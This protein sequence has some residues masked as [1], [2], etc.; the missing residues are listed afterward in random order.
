MEQLINVDGNGALDRTGWNTWISFYEEL[1]IPWLG[2]GT[3]DT[4]ETCSIF[5]STDSFNELS[6][7]GKLLKE[8]IQGRLCIGNITYGNHFLES[9]SIATVEFPPDCPIKK[10]K[11]T[12]SG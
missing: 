2:Y 12:F 3:Q 11:C 10:S 9:L 4:S 7:Q 8:T 6:D 5:K 1:Q